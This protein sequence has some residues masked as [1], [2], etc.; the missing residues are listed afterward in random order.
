MGPRLPF[1][2]RRHQALWPIPAWLTA[3]CLLAAAPVLGHDQ[4]HPS[5]P[6]AAFISDVASA[7]EHGWQTYLA[8]PAD[9]FVD[10]VGVVTHHHY[11]NTSYG[12]HD[13]L[14]ML[15]R[16][17]IRH[18]R[19][20]ITPQS[21]EFYADF[22]EQAGPGAGVSYVLNDG[23]DIPWEDQIRMVAG[24]APATASQI[25]SD[26][27]P[28]CDGWQDGE[29]EG[30][31]EL[32]RDMR[33][34]MDSLPELRE[35]PL[36][37]PSFCRTTEEHYSAYGDDGV[38]DR[39]N[40]HPYVAGL[41]PEEEIG[42]TLEWVRNAAPGAVPVVTEGG[43]HN[44]VKTKSGHLPTSERAEGAYLPQMFL[45]YQRRGIALTHSY[46]LINIRDD[47][48]ETK[49]EEHFGLYRFDGSLKPAGAS[50]AALLA[51]MT[52]SR[53]AGAE[54][55][56]VRLAA[57]GGGDKLRVQP[58]IRSDGSIDVVL[59]MAQ[60]IWDR[61]ERR[62]LP[63]KI[64]QITVS[65]PE[66]SGGSYVRIDGTEK[67]ERIRMGDASRFTVPVNAHPTVLRLD[68]GASGHVQ[69]DSGDRLCDSERPD[70]GACVRDRRS[71]AEPSAV[72]SST[73]PQSGNG[74]SARGGV[75]R[76][77]EGTQGSVGPAPT[78]DRPECLPEDH[79]VEC[80]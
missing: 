64:S 63:N 32:A 69:P 19:D 27:E 78:A 58:Y 52:D 56:T 61:D 3:A 36:A 70:G 54:P 26:N 10:T 17:N 60:R 65:V 75:A 4:Q 31:H 43:F 76:L 45:E 68:P 15:D 48:S 25:E 50:L 79:D 42:R 24:Q 39:F 29:I 20:A 47:P 11:S 23:E 62:D 46:E 37:T 72:S 6:E 7:S 73:R 74:G 28:D 16:L 8:P 18:I 41:L 53:G 40:I 44:A 33:E 2:P 14:K 55:Q 66:I 80:D 13:L 9:G 67:P 34:L 71:N 1:R 51:T 77:R 21:M 49:R 38:S 22:V 57:E 30:Y 59:W 12:E 35:V 5:A